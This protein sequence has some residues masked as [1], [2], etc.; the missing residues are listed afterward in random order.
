MSTAQKEMALNTLILAGFL[1]LLSKMPSDRDEI[2]SASPEREKEQAGYPRKE[3]FEVQHWS[4]TD[5]KV[6]GFISES[7]FHIQETAVP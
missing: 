1:S 3:T 5:G 7:V 4:L 6:V 2:G